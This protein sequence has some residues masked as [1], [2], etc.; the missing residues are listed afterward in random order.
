MRADSMRRFRRADVTWWRKPL[1]RCDGRPTTAELAILHDMAGVSGRGVWMNSRGIKTGVSELIVD[2]SKASGYRSVRI[3]L[4]ARAAET[5]RALY[6]GSRL[7][8]GCPDLVIWDRNGQLVRL[9]E[10][11]WRGHD[12][13][14]DEQASF[15]T[16]A[17]KQ[18]V[19]CETVE[20]QFEGE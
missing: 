1:V 11:K 20:W 15:M 7:E 9:V 19:A 14:S 18:K 3:T 8:K 4:P 12:V 5:L 6:R 2:K 13:E 16:Y 10:V 17:R